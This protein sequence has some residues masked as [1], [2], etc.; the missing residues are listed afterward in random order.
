MN[1]IKIMGSYFRDLGNNIREN[2][3][4]NHT[5]TIQRHMQHWTQD[6]ERRQYCMFIDT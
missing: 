5:W 4:V 2:R 6:T 3:K 1:E